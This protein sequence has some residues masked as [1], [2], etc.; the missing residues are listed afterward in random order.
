MT[1]NPRSF[2]ALLA[3]AAAVA[4][5]SCASEPPP[6]RRSAGPTASRRSQ[7]GAGV[8]TGQADDRPD[9][10]PSPAEKISQTVFPIPDILCTAS[11][12]ADK[13]TA[14]HLD[15]AVTAALDDLRKPGHA[16]ANTPGGPILKVHP[17]AGILVFSGTWE[18]T[19]LVRST[20]WALKDVAQERKSKAHEKEMEAERKE[21]EQSRPGLPLNTE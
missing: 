21:R 20:L 6:D 12:D 18:Q 2:L 9:V 13:P 8:E 11:P 16:K 19:E 15:E 14:S 5:M 10:L 17:E 4:N 1:T 3:V 7:A